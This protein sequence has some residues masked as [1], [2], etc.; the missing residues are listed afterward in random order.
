MPRSQ[1]SN[2]T[3]FGPRGVFHIASPRA[4]HS[5]AGLPSCSACRYFSISSAV[6]CANTTVATDTAA[7]AA[8]AMRFERILDS[9]PG[10]G[11]TG[12][13]RRTTGRMT[14]GPFFSSLGS[15]DRRLVG[16]LVALVVDP[17]HLHLVALVRTLELE[18]QERILGDGR[19]PLSGQHCLAVVHGGH[20]LDEPRRNDLALRVL[21][22]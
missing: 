10:N 19:P 16:A 15:G 8:T 1:R 6:F 17:R 2:E 14:S 11:A 12:A 20:V 3:F 4:S 5:S 9:P 22:L 7:S 21:A 13:S 18:R